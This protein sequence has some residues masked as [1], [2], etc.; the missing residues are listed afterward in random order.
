ME[1]HEIVAA[2][3]AD[4]N[5]WGGLDEGSRL[6]IEERNW[7]VAFTL[8]GRMARKTPSVEVFRRLSHVSSRLEYVLTTCVYLLAAIK[9]DEDEFEERNEVK[10]DWVTLK[11]NL[12]ASSTRV[13]AQYEKL[14]PTR[15]ASEEK[16]SH[17]MGTPRRV[18]RLALYEEWE[19]DRLALGIS[20]YYCTD[21]LDSAQYEKAFDV[22]T[23][24]LLH[25][26]ISIANLLNFTSV[27]IAWKDMPEMVAL[28]QAC[29]NIHPTEAGAW[30]NL[31]GCF[32]TRKRPWEAITACN[33][34]LKLD[35]KMYSAWNNLG[36]SYKNIGEA[37]AAARS[38]QKALEVIN[39]SQP[40]IFSNY[41]LTLAYAPGF[42]REEVS[43][44]HW[45]Y[46]AA[47]PDAPAIQPRQRL[48][49]GES[50][51]RIGFLSADFMAHSCSYFLL[52]LWE[53]LSSRGVEIF[54]YYNGTRVD[55]VT[56]QLRNQVDV[57]RRVEDFTD[58]EVQSI[59]LDD[60]LDVLI[61][62]AG[63]TKKNRLPVF[64]LRAAPVQIT[65]LG[66]PNT[67]G[68]KAMDWRITD[69]HCDPEGIDGLY[70]EKV[71]RMPCGVFA[72]Y[73]PLVNRINVDPE[74]FA[75]QPPP[76]LE[77][78]Y[79]T[80]GSCNNLAKLN[81]RCIA[82]WSE[83]LNKVPDSRLLIESPGLD[84]Q[85][86]SAR[87]SQRFAARGID[88]ARIDLRQ[89]DAAKQYLIYNDIDICL[90]PFPCNGGTTTFDLVWMGLPFVTLEGDSFVSRMGTMVARQIGREDWIAADE[91]EYL[92]I[93]S[94][95]ASDVNSLASQ[96]DAQR[97]LVELSPL[98]DEERFGGEFLS[99][100]RNFVDT[101]HS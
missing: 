78:G 81:D 92:A 79:V 2:L 64:A 93:A 28:A 8:L 5:H 85:E 15:Q 58:R 11:R 95:M 65:W 54:A 84:Q 12:I 3:N 36:N 77:N 62:P 50:S 19:R 18:D 26:D 56:E 22:C 25:E 67:T 27:L 45:K 47:F 30:S 98:M 39:W 75:V 94:R 83:I 31:G 80:F 35:P 63:H 10:E 55:A 101:S 42:S 72:A 57:W 34:A 46:G 76:C 32:D 14:H 52:P 86:F 6:A 88:R 37:D 69:E 82:L 100:L 1:K 4:P 17:L 38:Y 71:F 51:L 33:K 21:L 74:V 87:L 60:E 59:V 53:Y 90:D 99:M 43:E 9:T 68:V 23:A 91:T 16:L 73:R 41:L 70:T 89:R 61:D 29:V 96:R 20:Y 66:H 97:S 49:A 24:A 48:N 44:E 40:K 7:N 13:T